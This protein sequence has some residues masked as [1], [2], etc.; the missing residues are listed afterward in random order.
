MA[1]GVIHHLGPLP[2]IE[3]GPIAS[4]LKSRV[5]QA[6]AEIPDGKQGAI[7]G[8][9]TEKGVNLVVAHRANDRWMVASWIGKEW[10]GAVTGG[11]FVKATW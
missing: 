11:A 10:G 3:P 5:H 8:I 9:A 6:L 1:D 4:S 2:P 7:V